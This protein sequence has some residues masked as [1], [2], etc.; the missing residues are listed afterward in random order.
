RG[1]PT[2][3][4][5]LGEGNHKGLPLHYITVCRGNP[6]CKALNLMALNSYLGLHDIS[7]QLRK[8][9]SAKRFAGEIKVIDNGM[10]FEQ[11]TTLYN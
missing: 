6:T 9:E 11:D 1:N 7:P 4:P 2:R 3:K 5:L 8:M 10:Y